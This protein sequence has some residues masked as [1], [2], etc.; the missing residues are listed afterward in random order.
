MQYLHW[1][2]RV[3]SGR[4]G[5]TRIAIKGAGHDQFAVINWRCTRQIHTDHG[6]HHD[7]FLLSSISV[8]VGVFFNS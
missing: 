5:G 8:V 1:R 4:N 6:V 3:R 2:R 7:I